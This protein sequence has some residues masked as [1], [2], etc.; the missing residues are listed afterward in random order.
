[1]ARKRTPTPPTGRPKAAIYR[2]KPGELV[3]D[4]RTNTNVVYMGTERGLAYVRPVGGGLEREV[5]PA[6]LAPLP[7]GPQIVVRIVPSEP[8][9]SNS[10]ADAA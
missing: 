10:P 6:G 8:R 4:I 9:G 1:M 5:D 2:P 3:T 7:D